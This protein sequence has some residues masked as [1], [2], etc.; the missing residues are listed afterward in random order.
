MKR[1]PYSIYA[2]FLL[3]RIHVARFAVGV[4]IFILTIF[5]GF[6]VVALGVIGQVTFSVIVAPQHCKKQNKNS[7]ER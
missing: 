3:A 4:I 6:S 2:T 7:Q 5:G 1:T